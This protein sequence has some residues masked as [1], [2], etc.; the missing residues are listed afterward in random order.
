MNGRWLLRGSTTASVG[1]SARVDSSISTLRSLKKMAQT[2]ARF[3]KRCRAAFAYN[4]RLRAGLPP[5]PIAAP[6]KSSLKPP[7]FRYHRLS[8]YVREPSRDDGA[9]T[10]YSQRTR[11]WR[12][13]ASAAQLGAQRDAAA[14]NSSVPRFPLQLLLASLKL[15]VP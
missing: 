2:M 1:T 14:A 7:S 12:W 3:T 4:T 6:G 5:G 10:F 13:R 11:L 8:Y 9:H 15:R